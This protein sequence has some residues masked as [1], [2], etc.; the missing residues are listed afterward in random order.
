MD[1]IATALRLLPGAAHVRVEDADVLPVVHVFLD[2]FQDTTKVQYDLVRTCFGQQ[3]AT[4]TAVGDDKQR[5]MVWA[6][7]DREIFRRF[8][9]DFSA[10]K[11]RLMVN[12]RSA[13]RLV[14][15]QKTLAS[16]IFG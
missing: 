9:D 8:E 3:D 6:G 12:H 16:T 11:K 7:A 14:Q 15:V 2:E 1:P 10:G 5:I 4:L 13:P